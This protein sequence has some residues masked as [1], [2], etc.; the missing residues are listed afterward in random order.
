MR[1]LLR[2]AVLAVAVLTLG[3]C[4][5]SPTH[6]DPQRAPDLQAQDGQVQGC[7]VD[8]LCALPPISGGW[9]EPWM[10]LDWDCDEGGE[11]ITSVSDPTDPEGEMSVQSCPGGGAGGGT[12]GGDG[13]DGDG[14]DGGGDPTTPCIQSD[15][16]TCETEESNI[17]PLRFL[18]VTQPTLI[19]VAGRNHEFQFESTPTHQF[20]RLTAGRSPATYQIKFP[21]TSRDAWW[22]AEAGNITVWCRGVYFRKD[23]WVGTVTVLDSDLHMVMGP[24]H[25]DF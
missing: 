21:A 19:T 15:T 13:A 5:D 16:G 20:V 1:N 14:G 18:G 3:A 25:P 24:G 10:E 2:L 23:W 22:I 8:G 7:V 11:C 4:A 12:G 9:C 6:S 17:C